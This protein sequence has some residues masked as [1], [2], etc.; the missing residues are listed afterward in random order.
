VASDQ[1]IVLVVDDEP[2]IVGLVR[3]VL[4]PEGYLVQS[5]AD[6][7][8]AMARLAEGG[9]DLVLLDV[10][11][12]D[13][14]GRELCKRVRAQ[15]SP[16]YVPI[17]MLTALAAPT[18]RHAGFSAGADDYLTKPFGTAELVDRVRVWVR[19]HRY[20]KSHDAQRLGSVTERGLL[21]M[22]LATSHDLTRLLMLLLTAL[23]GWETT[24]PSP[25]DLRRLRSQFQD[26]AD[27]VASRINLLMRQ[28]RPSG[29]A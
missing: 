24:Q 10:M 25:E 17:V 19:V 3:A 23:E 1:P 22:A 7:A 29:G 12:P 15:P 20:L 2:L 8:S 4:E 26:A 18:D 27:V 6:G 16:T 5:A 11:L 14:D 28:A 9:I 21:E 13:I